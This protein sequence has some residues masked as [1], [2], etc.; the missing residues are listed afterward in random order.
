MLDRG[1]NPDVMTLV[2]GY[3][4]RK[5]TVMIELTEEQQRALRQA[6]WP[7]EVTN[8]KTGETFVLIHKEMFER[9]RAFLEQEDGI[10]EIEEMYPLAAEV[11]DADASSSRESA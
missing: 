8:P 6:G 5:G 11:L 7:A 2:F 1:G 10:A 9:V 4:R 3:D